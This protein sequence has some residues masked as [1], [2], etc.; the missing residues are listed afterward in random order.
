MLRYLSII[1][2]SMLKDVTG[3]CAGWSTSTGFTGYGGY[4][5]VSTIV[6]LYLNDLL[7][8]A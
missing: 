6:I 3:S 4:F 7:S 8:E 1:V 2:T 5:G